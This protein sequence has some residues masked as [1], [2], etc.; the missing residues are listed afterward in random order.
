MYNALLVS[1]SLFRWLVVLSLI[2]AII[3]GL[4][5]WMTKKEFTSLD[6]KVRHWTATIVHIQFMLGLT[7]YFISPI[8]RHFLNNLEETMKIREVGSA[9][10]KRKLV[11]NDKFKTM[12]IYFLIGFVIILLIIPWGFSSFVSRPYFRSF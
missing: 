8:I 9:K 12:T 4:R 1:H 10:A 6:D 5:G 3:T 7:L 11:D 2:V